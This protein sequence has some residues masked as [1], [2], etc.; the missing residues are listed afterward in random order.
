[1]L[2]SLEHFAEHK[3]VSL[4]YLPSAHRNNVTLLGLS[5]VPYTNLD[6]A[7]PPHSATLKLAGEALVQ[8]SIS[9]LLRDLSLVLA[10]SGSPL[11]Y[12]EGFGRTRAEI[13][14]EFQCSRSSFLVN[15]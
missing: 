5:V 14:F 8:F 3:P 6:P 2:P 15:F 9:S 4:R 7:H 1:M 13:V 11:W 12:D 10:L